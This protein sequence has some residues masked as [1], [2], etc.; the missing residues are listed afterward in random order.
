MICKQTNNNQP[1]HRSCTKHNLFFH[2]ATLLTISTSAGTAAKL[3]LTY[4][5]TNTARSKTRLITDHTT[6]CKSRLCVGPRAQHALIAQEFGVLSNCMVLSLL[7]RFGLPPRRARFD[8]RPTKVLLD[9]YLL[10]IW[11]NQ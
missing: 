3:N 7:F 11:P 10:Y 5:P 4:I 9:T 1:H 2:F 6:R 8:S